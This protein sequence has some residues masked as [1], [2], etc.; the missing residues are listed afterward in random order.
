M[1]LN[2][3]EKELIKIK[4]LISTDSYSICIKESASL[5]ESSLKELKQL[6]H[7]KYSNQTERIRIEQYIDIHEKP[8]SRFTLGDISIMFSKCK[9]WDILSRNTKSNLIKTRTLDWKKICDWR[10]NEVHV[11]KHKTE[12]EK[13]KYEKAILMITWL[14]YFLIDTELIL[15]NHETAFDFNEDSTECVPCNQ[16][17]K[18]NWLFCPKCG[19]LKNLR[20]HNCE[21][22]ITN[23][24]LKICPFC[25]EKIKNPKH[26]RK[27]STVSAEEEYENLCK[28]C[29]FDGVVNIRE[30]QFLEFK[31]HELGLN[32]QEA[33]EIE[34]KVAKKETLEYISAVEEITSDGSITE[35]DRAYLKIKAKEL[36]IDKWIQNEVENNIRD[37][38][39]SD[40]KSKYNPLDIIWTKDKMAN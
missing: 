36:G 39:H 1:S 33:L 34:L 35:N 22:C 28:G 27:D 32:Y 31:R 29:W 2:P 5:F 10:N 12:S 19:E 4:K 7:S 40:S 16:K 24:S 3:I 30:R 37:E 20:C 18:T 14:K 21:K 38:F 11:N 6:I 23:H 15:V 9:L 26:S 8:Y 17:L 25:D 13:D